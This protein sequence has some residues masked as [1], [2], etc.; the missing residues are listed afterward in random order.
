MA[1]SI[2]FLFF[3]PRFSIIAFAVEHVNL[4]NVVM[5]FGFISLMIWYRA[6]LP[7]L[8]LSLFFFFVSS[9]RSGSRSS[10]FIFCI[11]KNSS[12]ISVFYFCNCLLV[13]YYKGLIFPRSFLLLHR[14]MIYIMYFISLSY[15]FYGVSYLL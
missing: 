4:F 5:S 3:I 10:M 2:F 13:F 8:M 15:L 11:L 6:I 12:R 9:F 14:L 1:S 7:I